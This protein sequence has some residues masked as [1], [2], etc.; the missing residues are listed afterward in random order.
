MKGLLPRSVH[1]AVQLLL[2]LGLAVAGLCLAS[3]LALVLASQ[4]YGLSL[5]Q[6]SAVGAAPERVPHGWAV[7]MLLQ[8]LS[9]AGLGA[10][11]AVLPLVL[12]QSVRGYF[13]PRRL[14]AAWW[15]LAAGLVIL[16]SVPF[17]SALVAWNADVHFPTPA[18]L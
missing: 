3:L 9:L 16:V 14:G 7:L 18:R 11:A 15:L 4:F 17:L 13:A 10:G 1:P 6:F 5:A 12:G 2:L 8:G